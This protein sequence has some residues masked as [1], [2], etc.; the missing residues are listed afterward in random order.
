RSIAILLFFIAH[1]LPAQQNVLTPQDVARIEYVQEAVIS[2]DGKRIAFQLLVPKDPTQE[3]APASSH[4]YV[5]ERSSKTSTPFV[6]NYST[7][8]VKFRPG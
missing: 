8:N 1:S 4:L 5:Y 3:N 2:E 7:G 6:T